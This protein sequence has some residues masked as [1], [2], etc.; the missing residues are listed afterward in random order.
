[1]MSEDQFATVYRKYS[2]Q[3]WRYCYVRTRNSQ[4]AE[5][6]TQE[7]F[8]N[9]WQADSFVGANHRAYLYRSMRNLLVDHW[10]RH[11][12]T[13]SLDA[14]LDE[15]GTTLADVI[16]DT[17]APSP[18]DVADR[19]GRLKDIAAA[20]QKLPQRLQDVLVLRQVSELS[21][22]ET[23]EAMGTSE[24]NVRVLQHRAL[25]ELKKVMP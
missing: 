4:L 3:I 21:V 16:E 14:P 2:D 20:I 6:M 23:A 24:G 8:T 7:V 17:D 15:S 22:R 12:P 19:K 11:K 1:M 10:R 9:A 18:L 5:D 25:K 13:A